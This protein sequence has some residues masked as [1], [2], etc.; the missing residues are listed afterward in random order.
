M[1]ESTTSKQY[2]IVADNVKI[3]CWEI[4]CSY[5]VVGCAQGWQVHDTKFVYFLL[6]KITPTCNKRCLLLKCVYQIANVVY[7]MSAIP[8]KNAVSA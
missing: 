1:G 2:W 4:L 3:Y 8:S 7:Y 5:H 6:V